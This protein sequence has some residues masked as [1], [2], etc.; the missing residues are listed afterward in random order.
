[1]RLLFFFPLSHA[2]FL[3]IQLETDIL[4]DNGCNLPILDNQTL[5]TNVTKARVARK[6]EKA[7]RKK[8]IK[9]RVTAPKDVVLLKV[10]DYP[11]DFDLHRWIHDAPAHEAQALTSIC[12]Y[13]DVRATELIA[14]KNRGSVDSPKTGLDMSWCKPVRFSKQTVTAS[15]IVD[16][17]PM[18]V[19]D[20]DY[21]RSNN[22][23][24]VVKGILRKPK[25]G[26]KKKKARR[27]PPS[28]MTFV[29]RRMKKRQAAEAR[30]AALAAS[31]QGAPPSV[32]QL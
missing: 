15:Y 17:P 8:G 7:L 18:R 3:S 23:P 25:Y 14:P 1:M 2:V 10:T 21:K 31:K 6:L 19:R 24:A 20:E 11:S 16:S 4:G 26:I 32:P 22:Q 27:S 13:Y 28:L 30:E 5:A 29:I 9:G 12:G